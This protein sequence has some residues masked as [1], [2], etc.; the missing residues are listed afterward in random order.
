M[1]IRE[2][3]QPAEI[4]TDVAELSER[5]DEVAIRKNNA[6]VMRINRILKATI[7]ANAEIKGLS[8]PQIGEKVRI[9]DLN[10]QG[11]IKC[12]VN[13]MISKA[14]G[15]CLSHETTES[16]PG[17]RFIAIRNNDI[18][19]KYL[20]PNGKL[21]TAH[22]VGQSA[23][24][25]QQMIDYLQG[26]TLEDHALEIDDDY[27]SASDADKQQII[28]LYCD[29][30]DLNAKDL[31]ETIKDDAEAKQLYD[32]ID[33]MEKVQSGEVKLTTQTF[34]VATPKKEKRPKIS[35]KR[36]IV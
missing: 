7:R 13:P 16:L 18:E 10:H 14:D 30:L 31:L 33:F 36:K 24:I 6:D 5:C 25:M 19:V 23:F 27:D 32:G 26:V 17:R 34:D 29:S 28:S 9:C 8:A 4:I 3:T 12:Y 22:L 11:D 21:G 1:D 20:E 2:Q 15:I 35:R